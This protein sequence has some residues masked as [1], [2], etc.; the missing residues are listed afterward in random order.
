[1]TDREALLAAVLADPADDT[2]RLV[3]SDLLRES[4][5]PG[6]QALGRFIW[7]GVTAARFRDEE[8][9]LDP[10]Y[11]TAQQEIAEVTSE[12]WPAV[13]LSLIFGI[14]SIRQVGWAWDST[15]DRVSVRLGNFTGIYLRGM[16]H[17]LAVPGL[18]WGLSASAALASWPLTTGTILDTPG[19]SYTIG[20]VSAGWR[21]T[22]HLRLPRRRVPMTAGGVIPAAVSPFPFLVEESTV[23]H[24][25][26]TFPDRTTLAAALGMTSWELI[27]ELREEAGDRWPNRSARPN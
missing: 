18:Q 7:A 20:P 8:M 16:L 9:I 17:E 25:A 13:W 27:A 12:G 1:V 5:I 14:T 11:Y 6:D 26:E 21:L 10:L 15:V 23:L 19:L 2:A 4:D 22:A 3:L 24:A